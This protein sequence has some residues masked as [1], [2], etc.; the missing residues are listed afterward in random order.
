[1]AADKNNERFG[2][3]F[4]GGL[5]LL[6]PWLGYR[7]AAHPSAVD[8]LLNT[9]IVLAASL[10][11]AVV[12]GAITVAT[13]R[14]LGDRVVHLAIGVGKVRFTRQLGNVTVTL[15]TLPFASGAAIAT[16]RARRQRWRL[17]VAR[18][19]GSLVM[20]ILFIALTSR[21]GLDKRAILGSFATGAAIGPALLVV[22]GL[23]AYVGIIN[24]FS[25]I[26]GSASLSAHPEGLRQ[27]RELGFGLA[28]ETHAKS[29]AHLLAEQTARR[30]LEDSPDSHILQ[31]VLATSLVNQSSPEAFATIDALVERGLAGHIRV[32][33]FNLWAWAAY[34]RGDGELSERADQAS[35]RALEAYP[36]HASVL[37]T[38]GHVL[39]W[40]GRLDEAEPILRRAHQLATTRGARASSAV[41]LALLYQ[42]RNRIDD[43]VEW[44]ERARKA[45]QDHWLIPRAVAAIEPLRRV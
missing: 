34:Q 29:G 42:A 44:L 1:M 28:S 37:D 18:S 13:A 40:N 23:A 6:A 30:G 27:L 3:L 21:Y 8:C 7:Y 22:T 43:A 32:L 11:L 4:F 36:A 35:L 19:A 39:L 16:T 12:Q 45:D 25:I 15:R 26:G 10:V 17:L 33:A 2:V 31:L 38:R 14:L 24:G 5:L 20:L 9:A 41:G